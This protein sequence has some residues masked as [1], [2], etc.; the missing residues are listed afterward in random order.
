MLV[1]PCAVYAQATAQTA[2][3]QSAPADEY[4]G[5]ASESILGIRNRL[6]ALDQKSDSDML[7]RGTTVELDDLQDSILD[8]QQKYPAD[9]WI[10][11]MMSRLV[12]DYARAGAASS[13]HAVAT[14]RV[15]LDSYPNT[16]QT[17]D[18]VAAIGN[19]TSASGNS[20]LQAVAAD[21]DLPGVSNGAVPSVSVAAAPQT[22]A[23]PVN[24]PIAT[25]S[26]IG[27]DLLNSSAWHAFGSLRANVVIAYGAPAPLQPVPV[28]TT[29]S[30]VTATDASGDATVAGAVI[31]AQTGAPVPGAIV[32]VAPDKDSY[33]V[34][35]TPFATTGNDGAFSVS[36]VA[37]GASYSVGSVSLAH[38]EYVVVQP[39]HGSGYQ[40]YHGMIDAGSGS[41]AGVIRLTSI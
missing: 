28:V 13:S 23:V 14:L 36:H 6:D 34:Q 7:T 29:A 38:A 10:P 32:F 8:W 5:T 11:T 15:M 12:S 18:A 1:T 17:R 19:E 37:L 26:S 27:G 24:V 39:P 30:D 33:D 3:T 20:V 9:P 21:T 22:I 4:F 31:D 2:S 40:P 41:S 35:S 16:P 25:D